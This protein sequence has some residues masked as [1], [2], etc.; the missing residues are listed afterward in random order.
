MAVFKHD[1]DG[2]P[3]EPATRYSD[4]S[5][6]E[7]FNKLKEIHLPY[8]NAESF[9]S[10]S[11]L[12][13]I[14][15][16]NLAKSNFQD[17]TILKGLD[18]LKILNLSDTEIKE[19][20]GLQYLRCLEDVNLSWNLNLYDI[21]PLS[22]IHGIKKLDLS[23]TKSDILSP[24]SNLKSLTFLSLKGIRNRNHGVIKW[25]EWLTDE[26]VE[27]IF[28]WCL[29]IE[30]IG[31]LSELI[32]LSLAE[33]DVEDFSPISN[34]HKLETLDLSMM[35]LKNLDFLVNMTNLKILYLN[36]I[37]GL[38]KPYIDDF[39]RRNKNIEIEYWLAETN[40]DGYSV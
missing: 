37:T 29:N 1:E 38:T 36:A 28:G 3:Y 24:L 19:I 12:K 6:I 35:H 16:I 31:N 40:E 25:D 27:S 21:S 4:I 18:K 30:S 14:E 5:F 7:G 26:E 15:I 11:T 17:T 9:I 33:T 23:N 2:N 34:L 39:I 22:S 32:E 8:M 13:N 10:L 20:N